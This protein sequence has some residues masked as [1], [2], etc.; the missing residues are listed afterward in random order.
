MKTAKIK[1]FP[2]SN[3]RVISCT[4]DEDIGQHNISTNEYSTISTY[5]ALPQH[6]LFK[7]PK[8]F[9]RTLSNPRNQWG[10]KEHSMTEKPEKRAKS[11]ARKNQRF[12]NIYS[13]PFK[14]RQKQHSDYLNFPIS[15]NCSFKNHT[16]YFK[17]TVKNGMRVN[18]KNDSPSYPNIKTVQKGNINVKF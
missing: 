8:S 2:F 14:Q 15:K 10:F 9:I 17:S 4:I 1:I 6:Q 7:R 5:S 12:A 16:D 13:K 3:K 18:S 11:V